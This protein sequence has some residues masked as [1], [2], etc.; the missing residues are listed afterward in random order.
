ML[1]DHSAHFYRER[2]VILASMK[3]RPFEEGLSFAVSK[4][5]DFIKPLFQIK[6][7]EQGHDLLANN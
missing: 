4:S 1:F 6:G 2:V 3:P 7:L 5:N